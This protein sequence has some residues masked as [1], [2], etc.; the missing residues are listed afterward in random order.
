MSSNS[1]PQVELVASGLGWPEG[2]TVLAGRQN[3]LRGELLQPTD[4]GR[5]GSNAAAFR[6]C[7]GGAEFMR[8]RR[9]RRDLCLSERRHRWTLSRQRDDDAVNPTGS[10]GGHG[11]DDNYQSRSDCPQ[12]SQRSRVRRRW[13]SDNHRSRDLQSE[14]SRSELHI[15]VGARWG[16]E[17]LGRISQPR[18][19]ERR[20]CRI[21]WFDRLGRIVHWPRPSAPSRWRN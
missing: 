21:G 9:G 10:R 1:S 14:Q 4:S 5:R 20:R 6:L 16:R 18:V 11:R 13:P 3:H 19:P 2:P 15:R 8:P 17:R 12:R 7:R